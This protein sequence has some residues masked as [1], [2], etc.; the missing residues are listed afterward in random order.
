MFRFSRTQAK[1][2]IF[3]P[4][5][6][7]L[8]G[9]WQS[10]FSGSPWVGTVSIGSSDQQS[11]TENTNPPTIGGQ[12]D[13]YSA[14]FNGTNQ[15]LVG[16][17]T[18]NFISDNSWFVWVVFKANI[19]TANSAVANLNNGLISHTGGNWGIFIG[20]P[21]G[22]NRVFAYQNSVVAAQTS[23]IILTNQWNLICARYDG[24]RIYSQL[25]SGDPVS[26]LVG[27]ISNVS[28]SLL[29]GVNHLASYFNGSIREI[30]IQFNSGSNGRFN[31]IRKYVNNRYSLSL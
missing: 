21:G 22:Q 30:G 3:S 15:R 14:F 16:S 9:W 27:S 5:D 29:V 19:I 24:S 26:T 23:H 31:D 8:T 4:G 13:G 28:G 25:N 17:A 20:N 6:G 2:Y 7:Y 12:A 18:S 11:L 10:P 1:Q